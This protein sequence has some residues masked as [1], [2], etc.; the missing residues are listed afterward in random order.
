ME[1]RRLYFLI[2][3][4]SG[5][6]R[7]VTLHKESLLH[8]EKI[9]GNLLEAIMTEAQPPLKVHELLGDAVT[10][11]AP[12]DAMTPEEI[13][14][15]MSRMH[16]AFVVVESNHVSSCSICACEACNNVDKLRLKMIVHTGEAA[17]TSVGGMQKISGEEVILT[18]RWLKNSIPSHEYF[19]F[20][21]EFVSAMDPTQTEA[22]QMHTETLE[23]LGMKT[24]YYANLSSEPEP[25]HASLLERLRRHTEL[26]IYAFSRRLGLKGKPFR[27]LGFREQQS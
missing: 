6:T 18:H 21:Q 17:F 8:A 3:D 26:N 13:F 4:I 20:T 19:L 25:V 14:A 16:Q 27:N 15:T 7:F 11:Y 23:G 22:L 2:A 5:Y 9:I 24:A 10:I 12:A 1:I